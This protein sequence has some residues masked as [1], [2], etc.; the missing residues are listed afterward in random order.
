MT[1]LVLGRHRG[2]ARRR[3]PLLPDRPGRRCRHRHRADRDEPLRP[4]ARRRHAVPFVADRDLDQRA[5]PGAAAARLLAAAPAVRS[6]SGRITLA[7][8]A[9][10]ASSSPRPC[11]SI[12]RPRRGSDALTITFSIGRG[13]ALDRRP[14]R[15]RGP[16]FAGAVRPRRLRRV[17]RRSSRAT[18]Q[19][20]FLLALLI[21]VGR[22]H[23]ARGPLRA[24]GGADARHQPGDRDPRPGHRD[25]ARAVQQHRLHRRLRAAPRSA[26]P[27]LF[28]W[29]INA[30]Q[31]VPLRAC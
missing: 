16:A 11:S 26:T 30:A 1:N 31:P 27:S 19:M 25:R 14:H 18:T 21:G 6:G 20:P 3:F 24:A 15:L 5:R 17:G 10:S 9:R 22:H 2:G 13:P 12:A 23:P 28:G 29:D 8:V 7:V 4:T